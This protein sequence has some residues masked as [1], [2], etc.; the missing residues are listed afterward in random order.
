MPTIKF[1]GK[2]YNSLADMP[3][4]VRHDYFKARAGYDV[5]EEETN[6]TTGTV[7]SGMQNMPGEVHDI[8]ERAREKVNEKPIQSSPVDELP[9][10]EDL[11]RRSAPENMQDK[12]SDEVIY[13]PSPPLIEPAPPIVE[14]VSTTRR[15][16]T[17]LL[18]AA[19]AIGII[20]A[21]MLYAS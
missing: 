21:V 13:Q 14:S 3:A 20:L 17:G 11:Y 9:R 15:L 10:T 7:P 4:N 5:S 18:V 2:E 8:Y 16:V 12:P 6:K 19:L 1:R